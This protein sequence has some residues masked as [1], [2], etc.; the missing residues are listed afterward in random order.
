MLAS[1]AS[2]VGGPSAAQHS[3]AQHS[4]AHQVTKVK[5]PDLQAGAYR[6]SQSTSIEAKSIAPELDDRGT[7]HDWT[8]VEA[9]ATERRARNLK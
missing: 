1:A 6:D 9:G 5:P 2:G 7:A 3:T 8:G 4:G